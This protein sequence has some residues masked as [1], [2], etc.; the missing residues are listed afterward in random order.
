M[1]SNTIKAQV[2]A[3]PRAAFPSGFEMVAGTYTGYGI[4]FGGAYTVTSKDSVI[5]NKSGGALVL[6]LPAAASC[7]N[8]H[9]FVVTKSAT[10]VTSNAS[11]VEPLAGG[12][13]GTAILAATAG[14]WAHLVSDGTNWVIVGSN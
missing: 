6:T 10:A 7:T 12:A 8:R 13:A 14:K 3:S 5:T 11:N 4:P 2:A 9:L 1:A